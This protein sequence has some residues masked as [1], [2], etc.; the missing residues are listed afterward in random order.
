MSINR[1]LIDIYTHLQTEEVKQR[2]EKLS[3]TG[4]DNKNDNEFGTG[5]GSMASNWRQ[6]KSADANEKERN[7]SK[8]VKNLVLVMTYLQPIVLLLRY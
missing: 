8:K 4:N 3:L 2:L 6:A 7:N 5:T 1:A